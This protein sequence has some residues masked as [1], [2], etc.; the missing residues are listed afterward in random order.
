MSPWSRM[1]VWLSMR[2]GRHVDRPRST[3]SA[4]AGTA[5]PGPTCLIRSPSTSTTACSATACDLPSMR[6]PQRRATC[7]AAGVSAA[8]AER[9]DAASATT[10]A[11]PGLIARTSRLRGR[12][13]SIS[14][15]KQKGPARSRRA[16]VSSVSPSERLGAVLLAHL[17]AHRLPLRIAELPVAVRIEALHELGPPGLAVALQGGLLVG[18]QLAVLV[19]VVLLH[20]PLA[21]L[22]AVP[23]VAHVRHLLARGLP[24]GVAELTVAVGVEPLDELL[25]PRLA[26][27]VHGGLLVGID[28]PVLVHVVLLQDGFAAPA[29][30][31]VTAALV[32][33]DGAG[34]RRQHSR[35][36]DCKNLSH[37]V[38][39]SPCGSR[40]AASLILDRGS[41]GKLS[42]CTISHAGP[43][44]GRR[45][46]RPGP[47]RG[48]G[49]GPAG[50]VRLPGPGPRGPGPH[51]ARPGRPCGRPRLPLPARARPG[52]RRPERDLRHGRREVRPGGRCAGPR[53]PPLAAAGRPCRD[54]ALR[55]SPSAS[56]AG[57]GRLTRARPAL[58][59]AAGSGRAGA[60]CR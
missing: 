34:A 60:P 29:A 38:S 15:R 2:P 57:T 6:R 37:R 26:V 40:G 58:F 41:R 55:P 31:I 27:A 32:R 10:N 7:R 45:H 48:G 39:T 59:A 22:P 16:L 12:S 20:H 17:L 52:P 35:G 46:R 47:G 54:R 3:T 28:L 50:G 49:G 18:I 21:H 11:F 24:L 36:H 1:C 56:P 8:W 33:E 19:G 13:R 5:T 9:T 23:A 25:A 42:R 4:P 51:R 53:S 44:L 43:P 30:M 14:A